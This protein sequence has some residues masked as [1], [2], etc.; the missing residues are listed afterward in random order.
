MQPKLFKTSIAE[1]VP[2]VYKGTNESGWVPLGNRVLVLPDKAAE[3]VRGVH[4]T[5]DIVGRHTQASEAGV[6]VAIGDG[7]FEFNADGVTPYKGVRPQPG[8]RVFVERYAGQLMFGAD[9]EVYRIMDDKS[10]GAVFAT[11]TKE[12]PNV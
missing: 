11:E 7:A 8:D 9:K 1:F 2:A 12:Q 3:I 6:I 5:P 10:I 4:M